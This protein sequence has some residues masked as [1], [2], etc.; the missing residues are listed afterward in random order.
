MNLD[1]LAMVNGLRDAM[2]YNPD[3]G[4][5]FADIA[6]ILAGWFVP[7]ESYDDRSGVWLV[8]F[9]DGARAAFYGWHDSSGWDC[10]SGLTLHPF[11]GWRVVLEEEWDDYMWCATSRDEVVASI[12]AQLALAEQ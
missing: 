12:E 11:D 7:A 6:R 9:K 8:E 4:R 10:R 3:T 5:N 2:E 1:D